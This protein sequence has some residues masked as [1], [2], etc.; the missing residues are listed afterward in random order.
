MSSNVCTRYENN[1]YGITGDNA[2]LMDDGKYRSDNS[3]RRCIIVR[4][5]HGSDGT[6]VGP[7]NY[8][9][10]FEI[11]RACVDAGYTVYSIDAGGPTTWWNPAAMTATAAA[12]AHLKA[13]FGVSKVAFF[14]GS[15]GGGVLL[16]A[17]K[18]MHAD[19]CGLASISGATD[20]DYFHGTVGYVPAYTYNHAATP[21]FGNWKAEVAASYGATDS[22]WV[23]QSAGHHIVDEYASWR[24]LCPIRWWHGDSD[25]VVPYAQAK[26][27]VDGVNDPLVTLRTLP[28]AFH[29]P[30]T[31]LYL[32]PATTEYLDFFNSLTWT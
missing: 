6:G 17:L 10:F 21:T 30:P 15:M 29:T 27:F 16:Q 1:A 19:V 25:N 4:S 22:T 24:G 31:P 2:L 3:K 12:I 14:G 9:A 18:T 20:L 5:G 32:G 11:T 8:G 13:I 26:A 7:L 23:A 28:G